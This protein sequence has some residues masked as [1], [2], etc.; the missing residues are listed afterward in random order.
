MMAFILATDFDFIAYMSKMAFFFLKAFFM[1]T[2]FLEYDSRY[3]LC[4]KNFNVGHDLQTFQPFFF[5]PDMPIGY[6]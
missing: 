3:T 2:A 6:H 1:P 5:I 4:G